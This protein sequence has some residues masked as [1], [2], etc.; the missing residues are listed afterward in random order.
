METSKSR[1]QGSA[2][3]YT[4]LKAIQG[5]PALYGTL[6]AKGAWPVSVS[7]LSCVCC[8]YDYKA[9]SGT[10]SSKVQ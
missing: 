1:N 2:T 5:C 3:K 9:S 8:L 6:W 7:I 10:M 4:L